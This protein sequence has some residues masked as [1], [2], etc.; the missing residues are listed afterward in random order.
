MLRR[1]PVSFL[2]FF[3]V[4]KNNDLWLVRRKF[5]IFLPLTLCW[6]II[7]SFVAS[8][9]STSSFIKDL[10]NPKVTKITYWFFS[11]ATGGERVL[12]VAGVYYAYLNAVLLF[13]ALIAALA[14]LSIVVE[15][16][17]LARNLSKVVQF[18][19]PANSA[20]TIPEIALAEEKLR[21]VWKNSLGAIF[22]RRC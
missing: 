15:V 10:S 8:G 17:S 11:E 22:G 3:L 9:V 1:L 12:N 20:D 18:T 21:L 6:P 16:V 14:Y 13:I 4:G 2:P 5:H 19:I 7:L